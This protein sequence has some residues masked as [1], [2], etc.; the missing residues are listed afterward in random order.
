M[1]FVLAGN[2]W[3]IHIALDAKFMGRGWRHY[4]LNLLGNLCVDVELYIILLRLY[5]VAMNVS[6]SDCSGGYRNVYR[7]RQQL[8]GTSPTDHITVA[9]YLKEVTTM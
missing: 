1:E 8:F 5:V 9:D 3:S 7:V 6:W 2:P 4:C